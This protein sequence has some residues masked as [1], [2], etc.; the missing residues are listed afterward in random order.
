MSSASPVGAAHPPCPEAQGEWGW[1]TEEELLNHIWFLS[2]FS[3]IKSVYIS[4]VCLSVFD[5]REY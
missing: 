2:L 4:P 5:I 3:K 1:E